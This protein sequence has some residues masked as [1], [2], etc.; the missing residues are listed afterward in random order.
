VLLAPP[1]DRASSSVTSADTNGR[2]SPITTAW[3]TS[4]LARSRS[5]SGAG[6]TF[7]PAAVTISSFLRPVIRR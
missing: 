4:A 3:L 5:S 2:P 7:L 6:A 1:F